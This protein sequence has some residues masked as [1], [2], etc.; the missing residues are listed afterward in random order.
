MYI[1]G[2]KS[3]DLLMTPNKNGISKNN[4]SARQH[5]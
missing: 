5:T 4:K 1:T 3:N 2:V